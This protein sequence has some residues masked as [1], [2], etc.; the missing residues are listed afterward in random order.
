MIN[1]HFYSMGGTHGDTSFMTRQEFVTTLRQQLKQPK[2][3][4]TQFP[5]PK[6]QAEYQ[7]LVTFVQQQVLPRLSDQ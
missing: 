1:L 6:N 2:L 3:D 5:T 7:Q 4:L